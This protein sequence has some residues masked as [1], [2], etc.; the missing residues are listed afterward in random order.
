MGVKMSVA[1]RREL[2][3]HIQQRY[4]EA[5]YRDKSKIIYEFCTLTKSGTTCI[6]GST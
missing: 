4:K 5:N 1:T 2:L 6:A 3:K